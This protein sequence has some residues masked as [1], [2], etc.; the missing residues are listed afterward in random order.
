MVIN[1]VGKVGESRINVPTHLAF[2]KDLGIC[3]IILR[4]SVLGIANAKCKE[5]LAF[6]APKCSKSGIVKTQVLQNFLQYY[7]IAILPLELHCSSIVKKKKLFS[8]SP[9]FLS[10][11]SHY[12][13]SLLSLP[14][15]F[16]IYSLL[17]SDP[18]IILLPIATSHI[19]V[20]GTLIWV[21][22]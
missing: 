5:N 20:E 10:P 16:L 2:I 14:S 19:T 18:N 17:S 1:E 3:G 6:Q 15:L 12:L 8:F 11:L 9:V 13:C 7:Y 4:A 22:F 21:F